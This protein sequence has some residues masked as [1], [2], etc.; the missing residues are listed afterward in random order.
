MEEIRIVRFEAAHTGWTW[1]KLIQEL[2]AV[3]HAVY[4]I[5]FA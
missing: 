3:G 4:R 2:A 1:K 5:G